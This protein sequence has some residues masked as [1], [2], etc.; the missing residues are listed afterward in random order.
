MRRTFA[1]LFLSLIAACA[2]PK[3]AAPPPTTPPAPAP[4]QKG[5][6]ADLPKG[7]VPVSGPDGKPLRGAHASVMNIEADAT[8]LFFVGEAG[9]RSAREIAL[10]YAIVLTHK[11][12]EMLPSESAEDHAGFAWR[13]KS[14]KGLDRSGVVFVF[15]VAGPPPA[16][17]AAVGEWPLEAS[18]A[19]ITDFQR[20]V[21]SVR[22]E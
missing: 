6:R 21:E 8:V 12:A 7:W 3:A 5:V 11:G 14:E 13:G 4:V 10:D 2:G 1:L 16:V 22:V 18:E 15:T 17:V 9:R 19:M 20:I